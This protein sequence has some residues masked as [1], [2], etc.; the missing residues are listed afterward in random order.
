MANKSRNGIVADIHV[1]NTQDLI[2]M[3]NALE[4]VQRA[5]TLA[6]AKKTAYKALKKTGLA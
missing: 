2:K 1:K 3:A 6:G 4:K 5:R